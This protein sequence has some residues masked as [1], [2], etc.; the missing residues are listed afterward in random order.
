MSLSAKILLG[1]GLGIFTGL[2]FGEKVTFLNIVGDGF[3]QLLQMTILPFVTFSLILGLGGLTYKNA[4]LL[5]KKC[6]LV[7]LVLW[8]V[9]ITVVAIMPFAFPNW[10]SASF[11]SPALVEQRAEVDFLKLYI[12]ANPFFSLSHSIVPATVV[13]SLAMGIALIGIEAKRKKG[14]LDM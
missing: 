10:V 1:M 14:L 8:G 11:F 6:G 3:I 9:G 2:F 5:G 12:P 13:F 7:L 4:L